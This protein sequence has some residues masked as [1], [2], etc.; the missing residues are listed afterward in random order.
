[1]LELRN[2]KNFGLNYL[3]ECAQKI[4]LVVTGCK[5]TESGAEVLRGFVRESAP[6]YVV[7]VRS[8]EK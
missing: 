8:L 3:A 2:L 1:M 4:P 5:E 6:G 7:H